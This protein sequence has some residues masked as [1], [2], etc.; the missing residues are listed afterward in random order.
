MIVLTQIA[1]KF[2]K[3]ILNILKDLLDIQVLIT[4][5]RG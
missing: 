2:T 1:F 3:K 4:H 5:I